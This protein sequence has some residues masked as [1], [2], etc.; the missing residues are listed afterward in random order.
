MEGGISDFE[1]VEEVASTEFVPPEGEEEGGWSFL[2]SICSQKFWGN[3]DPSD[4]TTKARR[5]KSSKWC[6]QKPGMMTMSTTDV[7]TTH[8]SG[9]AQ[10]LHLALNRE[11]LEGFL[12]Q[13]CSVMYGSCQLL[14]LG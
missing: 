9:T 11:A 5:V 7:T 10:N 1:A 13:T 3:L 4:R 8:Y 14:W 2:G 12:H 6:L